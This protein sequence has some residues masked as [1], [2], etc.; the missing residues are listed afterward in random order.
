MLDLTDKK[1][2]DIVKAPIDGSEIKK[3]TFVSSNT[4]YR[5]CNR[6][7]MDTTDP[8]ITFNNEGIC[9]HCISFDEY[10]NLSWQKMI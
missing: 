4:K 10:T 7:V 2:S 3:A 9:S 1:S 8:G 5:I 6:C